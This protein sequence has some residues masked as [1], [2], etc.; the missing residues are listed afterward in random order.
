M[1]RILPPNS[2]LTVND[3]A[4]RLGV[5][6]KTVRNMITRGELKAYRIGSHLIRVAPGDFE[7]IWK[8]V[9]GGAFD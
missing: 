7:A 1:G 2:P 4:I 6:E 9:R 5:S 8:P 3:C